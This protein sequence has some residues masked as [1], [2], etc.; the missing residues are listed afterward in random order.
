MRLESWM[1][2]VSLTAALLASGM[3]CADDVL[4]M[5]NGDR[6]TGTISKI[7]DKEVYIEPPYADEI[8]IDISKV[9]SI[10]AR[11][12]FDFEMWTGEKFTGQ[13][14]VDAQ[15]NQVLIRDGREAPFD[16]AKI[17]E[18][19]EP[20]SP[21]EWETRIDVNGDAS[22]GNTE[23]RNVLL[24]AY[25]MV[26]FGDHRHIGR[27]GYDFQQNSGTT[28][29]NSIDA[30]YNYN[31]LFD[32]EERWYL[33]GLANYQRDPS[34]ELWQRVVLGVGLGYEFFD[35]AHRAFRI[36]AGPAAVRQEQGQE[37]TKTGAAV[38][39]LNF[40]HK[41]YRNKFEFFHWDSF[42]AYTGGNKARILDTS[43]GF[44]LEFTDDIYLNLQFDYDYNTK[45]ALG[46]KNADM[47]FLVGLGLTAD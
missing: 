26:R 16:L 7:W 19:D 42:Y 38:W 40:R 41:F 25:G 14:G 43:T 45:P 24:Q 17:E 34:Q 27:V 47:R 37:T 3:A 6:I 31:W 5:K 46:K 12:D 11:R 30:R 35:D 9:K 33:D 32:D 44:R 2:A 13:F 10:D 36:S 8:K 22:W 15:G 20:Q 39:Q 23:T 18:I 29:K 1:H 21:F 4:I 28:V